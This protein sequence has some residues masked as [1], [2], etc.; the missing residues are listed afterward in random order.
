MPSKKG[1]SAAP[2]HQTL[3]TFPK[4]SPRAYEHPRGRAALAALD[5]GP[6]PLHK[7]VDLFGASRVRGLFL[8][9]SIKVSEDQFPEVYAVYKECCAILDIAPPELYVSRDPNGHA[10][11][12]GTEQPFIVVSAANLKLLDDAPAALRFMLGRELGHVLSGHTVLNSAL[13]LLTRMRTTVASVP[14]AGIAVAGSIAAL[15]E[16]QES[17]ELSSDRAGLLCAQ[18]LE[19]VLTY[20]IRMA[21]G[22][23]EGLD[24]DAFLAQEV[25]Y[26]ESK[27]FLDTVV[28][29]VAAGSASVPRYV[30]RY[31]E[32]QAWSTTPAYAD[33][34]GGDY[35]KRGEAD[36]DLG[37]EVKVTVKHYVSEVTGAASSVMGRFRR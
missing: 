4:I 18:E 5:R 6:K 9:G 14:F 1:A 33:V 7:M 8:A 31:R 34:M 22:Y 19:G 29:V 25:A 28:K 20:C 21:S 37:N 24:R 3:K 26:N 2:K 35:P 11:A 13:S 12:L 36:G 16:W 15:N 32:L 30:L 23:T 10:G 27:S 17:S